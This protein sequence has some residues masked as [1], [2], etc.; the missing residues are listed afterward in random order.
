MKLPRNLGGQEMSSLLG[1]YGY[2]VTR[3]TGSHLRLSSNFKGVEHHVTIP[4][5]KSLKIGTLSNILASVAGYLEMDRQ[6]LI[7]SLFE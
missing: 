6:Q 5:H 1:K 2:R 7:D 4:R 3:Q